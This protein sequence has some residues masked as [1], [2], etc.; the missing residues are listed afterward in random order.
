VFSIPREQLLRP[1]QRR[2]LMRRAL[3]GVVPAEVLDRKRKA[4]VERAPIAAISAECTSLT[5]MTQDRAWVSFG[6]TDADALFESLQK[7]Q[8]GGK[9]PLVPLVRTFTLAVWLINL[10]HWGLLDQPKEE[11]R[12]A[13][14]GFEQREFPLGL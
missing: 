11:A 8:K 1:Y 2:S 6:I 3:A 9:V 13:E 12:Q 5:K 7:V 10:A 4:F 14:Q